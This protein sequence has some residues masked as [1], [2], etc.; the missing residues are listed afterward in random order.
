MKGAG[1]VTLKG[2]DLF[3]TTAGTE[4]S[5]RT[6][7][8]NL[9]NALMIEPLYASDIELLDGVTGELHS[10]GETLRGT[11]RRN[12]SAFVLASGPPRTRAAR[13]E[14]PATPVAIPD[15]SVAPTPVAVPPA[16]ESARPT[17]GELDEA[18]DT[19]SRF[20]RGEREMP[21]KAVRRAHTAIG[22]FIAERERQVRERKS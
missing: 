6:S 13:K 7:R 12:G 1:K 4:V 16:K 20:V 22:R 15:A 17:A 9:T 18:A 3:V 11:L 14:R 10:Q 2:A 8:D 5:V 21:L 19:I